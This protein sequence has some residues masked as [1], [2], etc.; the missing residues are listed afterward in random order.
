VIRPTIR[1]AQVILRHNCFDHMHLFECL[2]VA[3]WTLA[4]DEFEHGYRLIDAVSITI[5]PPIAACTT[6]AWKRCPRFISKPGARISFCRVYAHLERRVSTM[7][8]STPI[9]IAAML[10]H[11]PLG[12]DLLAVGVAVGAPMAVVGTGELLVTRATGVAFGRRVQRR[13]ACWLWRQ[14]GWNLHCLAG[15]LNNLVGFAIEQDD[16]ALANA[17]NAPHSGRAAI[18]LK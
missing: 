15:A 6:R 8:P 12:A 5:I 14:R 7:T 9:I 2:L 18:N 1:R 10:P 13:L 17:K 16:D 3:V 4:S 11:S